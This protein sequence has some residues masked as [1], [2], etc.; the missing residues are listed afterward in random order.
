M[1]RRS[2]TEGRFIQTREE[3]GN[4]PTEQTD[5]AVGCMRKEESN[6]LTEQKEKQRKEARVHSC[7]ASY[8]ANN[9]HDGQSENK[10]LVCP[11]QSE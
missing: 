1:G 7:E 10:C 9:Q 6:E 4:M 2:E 11:F 8:S 5:R 3:R